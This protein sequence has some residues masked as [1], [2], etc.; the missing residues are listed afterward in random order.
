MQPE[1]GACIN[2]LDPLHWRCRLDTGAIQKAFLPV[3]LTFLTCQCSKWVISARGD[4]SKNTHLA[5]TYGQP[6]ASGKCL[7]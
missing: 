4:A 5:S 3:D 6:A 2:K 1:F 7:M